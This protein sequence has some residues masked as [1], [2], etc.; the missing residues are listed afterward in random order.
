MASPTLLAKKKKTKLTKNAECQV[1]LPTRGSYAAE[2]LL[3]DLRRRE[4]EALAAYNSEQEV[5]LRELTTK[6]D[7]Y[8]TPPFID[9]DKNNIIVN[10]PH[11][12]EKKQHRAETFDTLNG[13]KPTGKQEINKEEFEKLQKS[14]TKGTARGSNAG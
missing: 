14:F 6:P 1:K 5:T 12:K 13:K 4:L 9:E 8:Q 10:N 3:S 7:I 2:N 11:V